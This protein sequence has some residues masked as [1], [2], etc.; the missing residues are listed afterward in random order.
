MCT[1]SAWTNLKLSRV[2]AFPLKE[3]TSPTL[4]AT[5]VDNVIC[6]YGVPE[7]LHSDQG[8]NFCSE[9]ITKMCSLL[10]IE[11]IRTVAYHPQG[12]S[13]VEHFNRTVEAILAKNSQGK[14][15]EL[16][17]LP[18]ESNLCFSHSSTRVHRV[19]TLSPNVWKESNAVSWHNAGMRIYLRW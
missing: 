4:A 19:L 18:P 16:G 8:P 2:E 7:N 1:C 9:V 14:P 15:K 11:Q 3:T 17:L 10:G 12:N 5:L 13:Q 6:R